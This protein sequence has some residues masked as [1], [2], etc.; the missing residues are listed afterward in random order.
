MTEIEL[1]PS[2]AGVD[3]RGHYWFKSGATLKRLCDDKEWTAPSADSSGV[4]F[5]VW[6]RKCTALYVGDSTYGIGRFRVLPDFPNANR[7]VVLRVAT[8]MIPIA[9]GMIPVIMDGVSQHRST[10][11]PAYPCRPSLNSA[12]LR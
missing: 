1:W 7:A 9:T 4:G 11:C 8:G 12:T 6:C 3:P 2:R 5:G 10:P